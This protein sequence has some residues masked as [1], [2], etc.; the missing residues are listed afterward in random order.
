MISEILPGIYKIDVPLPKNPLRSTNAYFI[1]GGERN[2]LIDTGFNCQESKMALTE[3]LRSLDAS[4]ETTDLFITHVH[5]DHSGLVESLATPA[6]TVWMGEEDAIMFKDGQNSPIWSIIGDFLHLS[7]LIASGV[8]HNVSKHPG[9]RFASGYFDNIT[10]VC[11][12]YPIEIGDYSFQCVET[13][14]HTDGHICLYEPHKGLLIAGDHILGTITPN[15]TLWGLGEDVLGNYLRNLDKIEELNIELILP[16][17]RDFIDDGRGRIAE[18][19]AHHNRRMEDIMDILGSA[20]MD[21]TEI[22][23][24]MKWDLSYEKWSDFP[25]G[26]KI[27]A[28]G[29]AMSH[30]YHMVVLGQLLMKE[31]N[32]VLYFRKR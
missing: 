18:L 19:K 26:Q 32:G 25:W 9:Y 30:L 8:E 17:H 13:A 14:G 28:T 12:G 3:G 4:M 1:R 29:E 10:T 11:E 5:S 6:T 31:H 2:L 27:F 15:I 21:V 23:S 7:G 16:G 22:A 24:R 20:T